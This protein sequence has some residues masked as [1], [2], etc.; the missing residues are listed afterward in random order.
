LARTPDVLATIARAASHPFLVGF[1][2]E[3]ENVEANA[4]D[5][6][7]SKN[8]DMIAANKVGDG[9][10]FDKDDN[11]LTVYWQGGGKKELPLATKTNLAR[12]LVALI[13]ERYRAKK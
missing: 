5:K 12:Q 11:A 4:L 13:A 1:A 9:L 10:A 6:L 8:L 3:T 2:A 7:S